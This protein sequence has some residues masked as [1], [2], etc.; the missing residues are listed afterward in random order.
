M[1]IPDELSFTISIPTEEGFLG[2]ECNNP[3]CK[4]YFK[5]EA[6]SIKDEMYCPYC[7]N[8]YKKEELWSKDQIEYAQEVAKEEAFALI[9]K[10]FSN[11]LKNAFSGS[12]YITFKE[13]TPYQKNIPSPP[14]GKKV[15]S[16]LKCPM[17][18]S[19]FQVNGIFGFCPVCHS[20]N[21]LMYDAN[22]AI[23]KQE[24]ATSENKERA[25]RHA[26]ADLV[27]TFEAFCRKKALLFSID[28][29][30][31][32]NIDHTR[33]QFKEILNIDILDG[34]SALEIR[35]IKRVFEKRNVAEHNEGIISQRYIEII[36]EDKELLGKKAPLS[37]EEL[38]GAARI[39]KAIIDNLVV[40]N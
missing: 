7:G 18:N 33:Q 3:E 9:Q 40:E 2:R 38:D 20:E 8:K 17:C 1:S 24:I 29:G 6:D 21:M 34:L 26:Y 39:L 22:W 16:E 4:K 13:G 15:D 31:F 12:E 14:I 35:T 30:R 23:I 10:E 32:Q 28:K 11:M 37:I 36:P 19:R 5:V 25:L 27:S